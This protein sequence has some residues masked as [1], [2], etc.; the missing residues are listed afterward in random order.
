MQK[1]AAGEKLFWFC[2]FVLFGVHL[3]TGKQL[4]FYHVIE[5]RGFAS[6]HL[7]EKLLQN[8]D[9]FVLGLDCMAVQVS[10]IHLMRPQVTTCLSKK[11]S[12]TKI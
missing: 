6:G 10:M 3:I 1:N 4:S 5:T 11:I 12:T 2:W 9:N 8:T 7:I